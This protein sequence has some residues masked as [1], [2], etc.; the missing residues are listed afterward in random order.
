[1]KLITVFETLAMAEMSDTHDT[2]ME[3]GSMIVLVTIHLLWAWSAWK[4]VERSRPQSLARRQLAR[5][6]PA[7]C[8]RLRTAHTDDSPSFLARRDDRFWT[9]AF[10]D[11]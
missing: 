8:L 5:A 11:V 7:L 2:E 10:L 3:R 6:F 1:M 9:G 4:E